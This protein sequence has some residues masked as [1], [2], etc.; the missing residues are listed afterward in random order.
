VQVVGVVVPAA[1]P[2]GGAV[3]T[4]GTAGQTLPEFRVQSVQPISGDCP[5][6]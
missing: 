6:R 2:A 5:Q 1:T 4:S 3:G